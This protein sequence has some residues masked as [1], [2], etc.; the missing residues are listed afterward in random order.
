MERDCRSAQ[1]LAS[2]MS[3]S[4]HDPALRDAA[5]TALGAPYGGLFEQVLSRAVD[6]GLVRADA[7]VTTLAQV[8][9]ALAYQQVLAQGRLVTEDGVRRVVDGVLLPALLPPGA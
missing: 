6:R 7:D 2:V 4:R 3:A 9:P 1:V 5:E 8:F